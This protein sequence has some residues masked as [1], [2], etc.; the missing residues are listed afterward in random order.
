MNG[1]DFDR[2]LELKAEAEDQE[3]FLVANTAGIRRKAEEEQ[4]QRLRKLEAEQA[5]QA[6][7]EEQLRRDGE[8][9]CAELVAGMEA[10][11]L[12]RVQWIRRL[13]CM[14]F[15]IVF[16]IAAI[17]ALLIAMDTGRVLYGLGVIGLVACVCALGMV[18]VRRRG[19]T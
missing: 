9:H 18:T 1:K 17:A 14:G 3:V 2:L 8:R 13:V 19:A 4:R 10:C 12:V 7:R 15:E 16:Y 11:R 5:Q 6:I